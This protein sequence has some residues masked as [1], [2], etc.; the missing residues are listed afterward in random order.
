MEKIEQTITADDNILEI[1]PAEKI[2][3][4]SI[5]VIKIKG[6]KSLDGSKELP[7]QS[8]EVITAITPMYCTLDSLKALTETFHIPDRSMLS[9]IQTASREADFIS[10][11]KANPKDF[12]V[13]QF[14]RVKATLDC[15]LH[16]CM[17][18]TSE[19]GATFTLGDATLI[20]P[21]NSQSFKNLIKLLQDEARKWQDAI[22]GYYNEGRS[23]PKATR[24]GLK[25]SSNSD[26]A[27]TTVDTI[28]NDVSRS[29]SQWS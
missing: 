29:V 20:D 1:T 15:L 25:S 2:L 9:F 23:K 11:G 7:P 24:I 3:D 28:L 16:G 14:T 17:E 6:L 18:K 19:G 8:F 26:V 5:Y 12:A 27:W 22:R 4:N 10:G 21:T 13:E